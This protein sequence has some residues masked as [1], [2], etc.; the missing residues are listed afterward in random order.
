VDTYPETTP[1]GLPVIS[2]KTIHGLLH[3][4]WLS[5]AK[6]FDADYH[7]AAQRL[8]GLTGMLQEDSIMNISDAVMPDEVIQWA[9][10]ATKRLDSPI[11]VSRITNA[12][13]YIRN[14]TSTDRDTGIS[15][16]G[17]LRNSRVWL[18][19]IK[20]YASLDWKEVPDEIELALLDLIV[21]GT[22]HI[23]LSRNRGAGFVK[24]ELVNPTPPMQSLRDDSKKKIKGESVSRTNGEK[25]DGRV[26]YIPLSIELK[27]R[28]VATGSGADPNNASTLNYI[29]GSLIRGALAAK[30]SKDKSKLH[31]F[32]LSGKFRFLNAYPLDKDNNERML[33]IPVS[34]K[35]KKLA[36]DEYQDLLGNCIENWPTEQ[37]TDFGYEYFLPSSSQYVI[38]TVIADRLHHARDRNKGRATNDQGSLFTYSALEAGQSFMAMVAVDNDSKPCSMYLEELRRLEGTISLG[39]SRNAGYGGDVRITIKDDTI[40][41]HEMR[42]SQISNIEKDDQFYIFLSSDYIG[43][44]QETGFYDPSWIES[45]INVQFAGKIEIVCK[46][47]KTGIAGGFN[48]KWG[49]PVPQT[50]VLKAGSAI[51]C[52][53]LET[54][55][56][57]ELSEVE[58]SGIGEK[59]IEGFGRIVFMDEM[60]GLSH[61]KPI[62]EKVSKPKIQTSDVLVQIQKRIYFDFV[63]KII[64]SKAYRKA[65]VAINIP[66]SSLLSR[67][68]APLKQSVNGLQELQRLLTDQNDGLKKNSLYKIKACIIAG[69]SLHEFLIEWILKDIDAIAEDLE[70]TVIAQHNSFDLENKEDAVQIIK[71]EVDA[72]YY[73]L[74]YID[75]LLSLLMKKD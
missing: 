16:T 64:F 31:E 22:R 1:E 45:E 5:M 75:C 62:E 42:K 13:S 47:W 72:D 54:I 56:K 55:T 43:R 60:P 25:C 9:A 4:T 68:R 7:R 24:M 61:L 8:I 28:L 74:K 71:N 2:G 35:K 18:R 52:K 15:E 59:R 40:L 17:S 29:P 12:L 66:T 21:K 37:L 46:R 58:G 26:S 3:D 34:W 67:L 53:A 41:Q 10:Y 70:F 49:M 48:R 14:Q 50:P 63:E 73:R 6:Y 30:L 27:S 20:L 57:K 51:K 36:D 38:N 39:K 65:A 44:N 33:P 69:K 11:E 32:I 19:G 23:G